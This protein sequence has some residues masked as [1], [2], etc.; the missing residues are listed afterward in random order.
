M[1]DG[2]GSV[3]RLGIVNDTDIRQSSAA[4]LHRVDSNFWH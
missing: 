4:I 2:Q 3:A 1:K